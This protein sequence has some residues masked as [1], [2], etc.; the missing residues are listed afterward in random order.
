[1]SA[2]RT[3]MNSRLFRPT[4]PYNNRINAQARQLL[5]GRKGGGMSNKNSPK[6]RRK[7]KRRQRFSEQQVRE[8]RNALNKTERQIEVFGRHEKPAF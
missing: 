1:M 3:D 8:A 2:C 5:G 7:K 6:Q 4:R